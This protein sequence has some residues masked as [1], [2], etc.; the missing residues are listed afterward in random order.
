MLLTDFFRS[1]LPMRNPIGFG[2]SDFIELGLAALLLVLALISRPLIEPRSSRF[3]RRTGWCML[4]LAVLPVALRLI[5]LPRH[6]VP[7]PDLYDEFGHLLVAD[8]LRHFRLANPVHPFH[9]FFETFFVIQEP[10]Y[11][12]IYPIGQGLAMAIGRAIFGLPWAG[13]L[14]A[15]GAFCSLCYWMLRAWISPGWALLGGLLAV[16]QFGPLNQWTNSYWGG[17][18]AAASGCLVFGALPRI[19]QAVRARDGLWLGIGLA[20][21]LITRPYESL[22]LYASVA[23]YCGPAL[24]Y[25]T[26]FRRALRPVGMA[27]LPLLVA[28][29]VTLSH[30]QR[31]THSWKTLPEVLSQISIRSSGGAYFSDRSDSASRVDAAAGARI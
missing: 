6:P 27:T 13:V 16:T 19:R 17:H 15:C 25:T 5:L 14:L 12:S 18:V 2:A 24:R 29:A 31:V 11:S 28:V 21:H 3:A 9:R 23:L 26:D 4:V 30:N 1:F 20:L 8:T 7:T 10:S 22:F